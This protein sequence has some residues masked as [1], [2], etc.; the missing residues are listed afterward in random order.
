MSSVRELEDLIIESVYLGLVSG[1]LDQAKKVF[2]VAEVSGRDVR[3]TDIS[4]MLSTLTSWQSTSANVMENIHG[5]IVA[6]EQDHKA[7]VAQK[8]KRE[9]DA[10]EKFTL[11]RLALES[12]PEG[13]KGGMG[14][15]D[16]LAALGM[17]LG[18]HGRKNKGRPGR[19]G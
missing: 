9:R 8:A 10:E 15:D 19:T 17:V 6:A 4:Q 3:L 16:Q 13:R 7:A 2:E 1:K 14:F 11:V 12:E 5:R 18:Q